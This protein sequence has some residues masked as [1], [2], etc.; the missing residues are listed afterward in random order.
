MTQRAIHLVQMLKCQQKIYLKLRTHLFGLIETDRPNLFGFAEMFTIQT[1][2][3]INKFTLC[4]P[5]VLNLPK[6]V[7]VTAMTMTT[8]TKRKRN[9]NQNTHSS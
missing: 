7:T 6:Y 4:E 9:Q 1:Y 2:N 5:P 8:T 3:N